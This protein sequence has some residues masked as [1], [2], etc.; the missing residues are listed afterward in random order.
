MVAY[1]TPFFRKIFGRSRRRL[2]PL[3]PTPGARLKIRLFRRSTDCV[4]PE[5]VVVES[6]LC[7][8]IAAQRHS[9]TQTESH[10]PFPPPGNPSR[11]R[12]QSTIRERPLELAR[13][14]R[15]DSHPL[16]TPTARSRSRARRPLDELPRV[17]LHR[18]GVARRG[19]SQLRNVGRTSSRGPAE[20]SDRVLVTNN[21][22]ASDSHVT[23]TGL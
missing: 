17:I 9:E 14:S 7:G 5:S 18:S 21:S 8:G 13:S 23:P 15:T 10:N 12:N 11:A 16:A 3:V 1:N 6:S 19:G 4:S 2:G 22:I 20:A